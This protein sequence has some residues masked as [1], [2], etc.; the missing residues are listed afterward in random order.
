MLVSGTG[1]PLPFGKEKPS[2]LQPLVQRR[3]W[4]LPNG[5]HFLLC[6]FFSSFRS[7][8]SSSPSPSLSCAWILAD[9]FMSTFG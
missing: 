7:R 4:K 2:P 1:A 8:E 6:H 5:L 3:A 9:T